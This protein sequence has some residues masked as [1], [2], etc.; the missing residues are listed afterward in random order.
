[1]DSLPLQAVAY[2]ACR[3]ET[4]KFMENCTRKVDDKIKVGNFFTQV[5]RNNPALAVRDKMRCDI[6]FNQNKVFASTCFN[7]KRHLPILND[8]VKS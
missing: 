5:T 6:L 4:D 7:F 1:M 8:Q 3:R 2:L